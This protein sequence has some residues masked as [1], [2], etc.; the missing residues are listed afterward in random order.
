MLKASELNGG[1]YELIP[2]FLVQTVIGRSDEVGEGNSWSMEQYGKYAESPGYKSMFGEMLS[3][4]DFLINALNY[5]SS[6]FVDFNNN[7]C[8]FDSEEFVG[9]L[10]IA[11]DIPEESG[12]GP[13]A[14]EFET[15]YDEEG[16]VFNGEQ[17]LLYAVIGGP[18][19]DQYRAIF[20]EEISFIGFP[21]S[22]GGGS[23]IFPTLSLGMSSVSKNKEAVWE[24][25]RTFVLED[26]QKNTYLGGMPATK[27]GIQ[28]SIDAYKRNCERSSSGTYMGLSFS[29]DFTMNP[30][31]SVPRFLAL[32]ESL[33][34]VTRP[35][36]TI[37]EIVLEEASAFFD[38]AR[39]AEE[40]ARIIQE[41]A[42]I[43]I[44]EQS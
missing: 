40:A 35:D 10:K 8:N 7:A 22:E 14:G 13:E 2:S 37:N 27:A 15:W 26:T 42:S 11:A 34:K 6:L 25:L 38:G 30:E 9:L 44:S 33:D 4:N 43:Y 32:L 29:V 21:S 19:M 1:L 12:F 24:F 39:T 3:R 28:H 20:N 5:N 36:S 18:G 23:S 17:A 41:R 31:Y 16:S